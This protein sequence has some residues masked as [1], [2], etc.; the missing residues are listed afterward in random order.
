MHAFFLLKFYA[1]FIRYTSQWLVLLPSIHHLIPLTGQD[2]LALASEIIWFTIFVLL[3]FLQF[4]IDTPDKS[5]STTLTQRWKWFLVPSMWSDTGQHFRWA[6]A[7]D[8]YGPSATVA[9]VTGSA[10]CS[11][12]LSPRPGIMAFVIGLLLTGIFQPA[13]ELWDLKGRSSG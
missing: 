3:A 6:C 12:L 10:S 7:T 8:G 2:G 4:P 1:M 13:R 11:S 5:F 9:E